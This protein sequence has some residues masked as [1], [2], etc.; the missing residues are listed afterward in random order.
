[1]DVTEQR[2]EV[3]APDGICRVVRHPR[4]RVEFSPH[5]LKYVTFAAGDV[6]GRDDLSPRTNID[7]LVAGGHLRPVAAQQADPPDA[8]DPGA[9]TTKPRRAKS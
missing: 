3:C 6:I 9:P 1:V 2:W 4:K 7:A 5:G 8:T